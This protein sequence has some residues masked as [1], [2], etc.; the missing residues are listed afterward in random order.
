MSLSLGILTRSAIIGEPHWFLGAAGDAAVAIGVA[1][2]VQR[3]LGAI[4]LSRSTWSLSKATQPPRSS[5]LQPS[6]GVPASWRAF[7]YVADT[8]RKDASHLDRSRITGGTIIEEG[9]R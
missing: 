5:C 6:S 2:P 3:Q 9:L 1:L 8:G 7:R 4:R